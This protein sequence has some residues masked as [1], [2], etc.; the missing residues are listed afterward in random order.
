MNNF[1]GPA[2]FS[3]CLCQRHSRPPEPTY[4]DF[5]SVHAAIVRLIRERKKHIPV[6]ATVPVLVRG[7]FPGC[8]V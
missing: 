7:I 8:A 4:G 6:P 1:Q 3:R 5:H 2:R